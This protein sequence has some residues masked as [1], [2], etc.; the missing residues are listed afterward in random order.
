LPAG[1]ITRRSFS[2]QPG[3]KSLLHRWYRQRVDRELAQRHRMTDFFFALAPVDPLERLRRI[4]KLCRGRV[5]ELE[6]HPVNE[7]EYR[8]LISGELVRIAD[9]QIGLGYALPA[10]RR[11]SQ[12]GALMEMEGNG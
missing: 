7:D 9:L 12:P 10:A 11:T 6:T 1:A 4:F 3:D 8:F 2:F 5:L